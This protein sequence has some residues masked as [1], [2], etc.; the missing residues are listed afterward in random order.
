LQPQKFTKLFSLSSFSTVSPN[1]HTPLGVQS[2]ISCW[3]QGVWE[4]WQTA[5]QTEAW[6]RCEWRRTSEIGFCR[7]VPHIQ[8]FCSYWWSN[9]L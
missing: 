3:R 2:V 4:T 6:K 5:W 7:K 8:C 1:Y 9:V